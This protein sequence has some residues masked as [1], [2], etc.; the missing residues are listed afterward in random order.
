M[1]KKSP[2]G[3]ED[4]L[5]RRGAEIDTRSSERIAPSKAEHTAKIVRS[6]LL[7]CAREKAAI[8]RSFSADDLFEAWMSLVRAALDAATS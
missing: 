4:Q 7:Q 3:T 5:N 8:D 6:V 1:A 2:K